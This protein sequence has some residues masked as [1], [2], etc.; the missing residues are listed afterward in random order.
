MRI[1]VI[2]KHL[3]IQGG[4]SGFNYRL[5][6]ALARLGHTVMVVTN[7][8]EVESEYRMG[9]SAHDVAALAQ[10]YDSR[11]SVQVVNNPRACATLTFRGPTPM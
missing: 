10:H 9:L 7:A 4:V 11:G 3:P 8:D 6:H 1:C 5:T 2:G